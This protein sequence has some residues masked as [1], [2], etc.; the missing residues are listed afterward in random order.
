MF[1]EEITGAIKLESDKFECKSVLNR[2]DVIGWLKSIVGFANASGGNFYIGV[3][4]KTNIEPA[5]ARIKEMKSEFLQKGEDIRLSSYGIE[6]K[7]VSFNYNK[8]TPV[9]KRCLRR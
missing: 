9:L 4:D 8:D 1:L 6:F 5:I 3:E 2:G 7:N